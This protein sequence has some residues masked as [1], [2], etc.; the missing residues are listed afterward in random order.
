MPDTLQPLVVRYGTA[1]IGIR[2]L[3]TRA[4][5]GRPTPVSLVDDSRT[6]GCLRL[7]IDHGP[8]D[9]LRKAAA[10]AEAGAALWLRVGSGLV[11]DAAFTAWPT[12]FE[13]AVPAQI[14][15]TS[16]AVHFEVPGVDGP[17]SISAAPPWD[18]GGLVRLLPEP[19]P[20]AL[21]LDGRE[22]GRPLL[23][24]VEPLASGSGPLTVLTVTPQRS[25]IWPAASGLAANGMCIMSDGGA[26]QGGYIVQPDMPGLSNGNVSW[27]LCVEQPGKYYLWARVR[28]ADDQHDSIYLGLLGSEGWLLQNRICKLRPCAAWQWQPLDAGKDGS[29]Q[30]V[31]LPGGECRLHLRTRQPGV[32]IERLFL[33]SPRDERP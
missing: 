17:L 14:D 8:A 13:S 19:C 4:D 18:T 31:D 29:P 10:G 21:E 22:I 25:I 30:P 9:G 20:G 5:G 11:S 6:A 26:G 16:T 27:P 33:T 7:T 32:A 24:A 1:A 2:V 12:Q 23:A 15:I 28:A 3:W